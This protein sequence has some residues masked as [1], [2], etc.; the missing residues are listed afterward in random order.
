[1][2]ASPGAAELDVLRSTTTRTEGITLEKPTHNL[3]HAFG[4]LV[5]SPDGH[6]LVHSDGVPFFYLG[7]TAWEIFHRLS[8]EEVDRYLADRAARGFT[9]LQA[10]LLSEMNG[11]T[12]PNHYGDL[13]LTDLDPGRP[14]ERYFR[15]VDYVVRAAGQAGMYVALVPT[16]GCYTQ[17]EDHRFFETHK[18]FDP[19]NARAYGRF[20]GERYGEAPNIIWILG[21][22]RIPE[23]ESLAIWRQMARGIAEGAQGGEDYAGLTMTFHPRGGRSSAEYYHRE[24]WLTFNMVQST[25]YRDSAPEDLIA[26]DYCRVPAKPVIN[27]E[28]GYER[29]PNGLRDPDDKLDE[30]DVRRFAYR[31]VFAGA[32]G[33]TY[34][35]NELWMMWTPDLEPIDP[36]E[37]VTPFLGADTP[38]HEALDYPGADQMRH[39][40]ALIESR[41]MLS[42]RP[43]QGLLALGPGEG[44]CR[45]QATRAAD[46]SY[47]MVYACRPGQT[48]TVEITRLSGDSATAWWYDPRTGEAECLE[49]A[50]PTVGTAAFTVPDDGPDRVLVLDDRARGFPPPGE[51]GP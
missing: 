46:G 47:A 10:V 14:N 43:D 17:E 42:R 29:I 33:H 22:D 45:L 32:C 37:L 25:H 31:S 24:P 12:T 21:G 3:R 30:F 28:P 40:R 50:L 7:D 19:G 16:W 20:L 34:G 44:G 27:G 48:L 26:A 38:W 18:I 6:H 23:G 1:M 2:S 9:A 35:A 4:P 13:P 5:A 41:P 15:H 36:R 11:L 49:E 51:L 8:R 39:L